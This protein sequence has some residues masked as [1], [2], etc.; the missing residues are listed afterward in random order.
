MCCEEIYKRIGEL[1]LA[2]RNQEEQKL[3]K[4]QDSLNRNDLLSEVEKR[5]LQIKKKQIENKINQP[6]KQLNYLLLIKNRNAISLPDLSNRY[7]NN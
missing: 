6:E 1:I 2:R 7:W 4:L 3:H 5:E